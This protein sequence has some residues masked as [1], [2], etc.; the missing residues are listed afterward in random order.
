[1]CER[2]IEDFAEKVIEKTKNPLKL[3]LVK[4]PEELP[5]DYE[6]YIEFVV[7]SYS[8]EEARN[9]HPNTFYGNKKVLSREEE[10]IRGY[11]YGWV[12]KE[13]LNK[14]IIIEIGTASKNVK[15]GVVISSYLHG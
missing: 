3:Y 12:A 7:A 10:K 5:A 14:L 2:F 8:K 1:M 4:R 15:E 11:Q 6:D 9:T 13:D